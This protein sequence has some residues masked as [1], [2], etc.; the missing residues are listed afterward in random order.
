MKDNLHQ[1]YTKNETTKTNT[2]RV[3]LAYH[4]YF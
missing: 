3:K 1:I 2:T 4:C